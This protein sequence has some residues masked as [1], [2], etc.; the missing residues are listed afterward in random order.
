VRVDPS[1]VALESADVTA[2]LREVRTCRVCGEERP[3]PDFQDV[4][5]RDGRIMR[6]TMCRHCRKEDSLERIRSRREHADAV[7]VEAGCADCEP[8]TSWPAVALDFDHRPGL[9]KLGTVASLITKGT[10]QDFVAEIAKCEVVCA[11]HHRIRTATR[12][13]EA[14]RSAARPRRHRRGLA[15]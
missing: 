8:G 2:A 9:P 1:F 4:K 7:K 10:W 14:P 5:R 12:H 11:N 3:I 6:R 15:Q 13:L